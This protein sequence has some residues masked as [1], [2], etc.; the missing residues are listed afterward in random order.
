MLTLDTVISPQ[1]VIQW[2]CS[3][4]KS[5]LYLIYIHIS[6]N[7]PSFSANILIY[8]DLGFGIKIPFESLHFNL[9]VNSSN[10]V[11]SLNLIIYFGPE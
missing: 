7:G 1:N 9:E 8:Y 6:P 5:Y 3:E 10:F 4:F 11:L 2:F